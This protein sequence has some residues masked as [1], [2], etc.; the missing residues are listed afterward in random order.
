MRAFHFGTVFAVKARIALLSAKEALI[1][2][3]L[4]LFEYD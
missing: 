2:D 1:F 3:E 4:L